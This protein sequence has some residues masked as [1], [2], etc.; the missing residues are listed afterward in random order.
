MI[1]HNHSTAYSRFSKRLDDLW[2]CVGCAKLAACKTLACSKAGKQETSIHRFDCCSIDMGLKFN[3]RRIP[4]H[5]RML[6]GVQLGLS[7]AIMVYRQRVL[8]V[9]AKQQ[10]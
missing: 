4:L 7:G 10:E 2:Q 3:F 5:W 8:A 6:I 1:D 9:K